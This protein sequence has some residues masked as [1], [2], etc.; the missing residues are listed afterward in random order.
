MPFD[1]LF[2]NARIQQYPKLTLCLYC[3]PRKDTWQAIDLRGEKNYKISIR[4][5][6]ILNLRNLHKV[7]E[8][9]RKTASIIVKW[10]L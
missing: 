9:G 1:V 4:L 7:S 3:T 6:V 2:Q 5:V 10:Y 8:V